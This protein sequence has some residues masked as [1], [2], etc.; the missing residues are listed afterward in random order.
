LIEVLFLVVVVSF[1]GYV[2]YKRFISKSSG[3]CG[4]GDCEESKGKTVKRR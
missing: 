2:L 4:C 1:A 3:G